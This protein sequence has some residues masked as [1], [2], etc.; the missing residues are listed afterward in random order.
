MTYTPTHKLTFAKNVGINM[1]LNQRWITIGN[2]VAYNAVISRPSTA[3][4]INHPA[5]TSWLDEIVRK[6]S[7][8]GYW[9]YLYNIVVVNHFTAVATI[10]F[11]YGFH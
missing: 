3:E 9:F 5:I 7:N 11:T 8:D 4:T 10:S 1:G 6:E 2:A